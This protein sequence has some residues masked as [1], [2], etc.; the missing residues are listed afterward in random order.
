MRSI[1]FCVVTPAVFFLGLEF[2]L[3]DGGDMFLRNVGITPNYTALQQ[4]KSVLL[5]DVL[6]V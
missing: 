1:V 3:E 6:F 2:E 4:K 5:T